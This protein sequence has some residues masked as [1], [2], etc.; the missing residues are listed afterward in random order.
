MKVAILV[1]LL[2]TSM[3]MAEKSEFKSQLT[4]MLSLQAKAA[5]AVDSALDVLKG[6]KNL[7]VEAQEKAD[8]TNRTQEAELTNNVN[9]LHSI[10]ETNKENG[11]ICD[12]LKKHYNDEINKTRDYL[13]WIRNRRNELIR[14]RQEIHEQRCAA[15]MLFVKQI[16]QHREALQVIKLLREDI[17]GVVK[18]HTGETVEF[19]EVSAT[20]DKL[21]N[22]QHLFNKEAMKS[23]M[24]LTQ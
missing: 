17:I 14:K 8:E 4:N 5:D 12:A 23:F 21:K 16:K 1:F 22:Y 3:V 10:A 13:I 2:A 9:A 6:L 24:Q 15:A 20:V 11:D 18:A 19:T 7:N